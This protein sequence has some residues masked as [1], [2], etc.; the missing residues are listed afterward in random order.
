[1]SFSFFYIWIVM[2]SLLFFSPVH[3]AIQLAVAGAAYGTVVGWLGTSGTSPLSAVEPVVLVAVIGT[4]SAVVTTLSR[5]RELSE[6]DP[7]TLVANR[8]G[9]D[10][11]LSSAVQEAGQTRQALIV[12]MI[13]VDHFKNL[14][15]VRGH[16]GGDQVLEDLTR[17]WRSVLRTGDF[18]ARIGGDEFVVILPDCSQPIATAILERLRTA[19]TP[20]SVTCSVGGALCRPGDSV[21]MLL[22]NADSAL[23]QAKRLGRNRVVLGHEQ[24]DAV[25]HPRRAR[26]DG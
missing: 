21:S 15:D 5:A 20:H 16:A 9:L 1:V 2:Y 8:R 18:L 12:A 4:T 23:Y 6:V 7:L 24:F 10:R 19:A 17:A 25:N 11:A 3:V 13:D 26:R 14:N 22:S